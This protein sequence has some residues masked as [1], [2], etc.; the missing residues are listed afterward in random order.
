MMVFR[1][2]FCHVFELTRVIQAA[3][4][5]GIVV[6]VAVMG[7]NPDFDALGFG[8]RNGGGQGF[9][10]ATQRKGDGNQG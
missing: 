3:A 10:D 1:P 8:V 5:L 4:V 7:C 2:F 6:A 9:D